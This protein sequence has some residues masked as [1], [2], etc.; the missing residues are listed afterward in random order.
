M[1]LIGSEQAI[2]LDAER[3][4]HAS[5]ILGDAGGRIAGARPAIEAGIDS[6]GHAAIPSEEGVMD[7][8]QLGERCRLQHALLLPA[9]RGADKSTRTSPLMPRNR[10][11]P[12]SSGWI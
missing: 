7:P 10:E 4:R 3:R 9:S 5:P 6:L 2:R 12:A 8:G 1:D 11:A